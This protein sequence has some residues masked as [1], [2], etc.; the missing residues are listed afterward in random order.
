M[1]NEVIDFKPLSDT[2]MLERLKINI[3][4]PGTTKSMI[5]KLVTVRWD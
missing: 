3:G 5:T 2:A 4:A 1:R